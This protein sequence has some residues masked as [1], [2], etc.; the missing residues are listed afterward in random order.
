[1]VYFYDALVGVLTL[2]RAK[3]LR[4][5][6]IRLAGLQPSDRVLDV[7]CGTGDLT[8]MAVR[9]GAGTASGI[10]ADPAMIA[11]AQAKARRHGA[12]I[13]FQVS[14]VQ[15]LPFAEASFDVVLSSLMIHHLPSEGKQQGLREIYRVLTPGGR[16]VIVDFK[17]PEGH[18]IQLRKHLMLH[19]GLTSGVQDMTGLVSGAGFAGVEQGSL[20]LGSIGFVRAVRS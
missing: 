15:H 6:T 12:P 4:S 7:G 20:S 13:D 8:L 9:A 2:G 1:M 3:T 18:L 10:D 11:Q 17:R 14:T 5:E 16:L 19:S